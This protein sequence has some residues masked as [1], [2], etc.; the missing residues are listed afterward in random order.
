MRPPAQGALSPVP[1][2]PTLAPACLVNLHPF[3]L[4]LV[5][6][7]PSLSHHPQSGVAD[8]LMGWHNS[9]N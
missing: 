7:P 1:R 2:P 8:L 9:F 5:P 3:V 6:F 4:P